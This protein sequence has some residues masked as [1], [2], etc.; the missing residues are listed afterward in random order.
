MRLGRSPIRLRNKCCRIS[1]Q[2]ITRMSWVRLRTLAA[3][4]QRSAPARM[5]DKQGRHH[6]VAVVGDLMRDAEGTVFGTEGFYIDL[7]PV[8]AEYESRISEAVSRLR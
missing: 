3:H 4:A 2:T 5:I 7:T 1:I 6:R 8:E